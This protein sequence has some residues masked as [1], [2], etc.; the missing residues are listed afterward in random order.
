MPAGSLITV[1]DPVPLL[2][3]LNSYWYKVK[4][5]VTDFAAFIVTTQVPVPEQPAPLQPV[6]V[7]PV[8]AVAVRVTTVL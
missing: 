4:V 8:V 7:E 1:P 5:A 6:N 3:T 2:L